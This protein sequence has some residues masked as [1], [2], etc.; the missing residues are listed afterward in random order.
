MPSLEQSHDISG[1]NSKHGLREHFCS[2]ISKPLTPPGLSLHGDCR[3]VPPLPRAGLGASQGWCPRGSLFPRQVGTGAASPAPLS[4]LGLTIPSAIWEPP[5]HERG[6]NTGLTIAPGTPAAPASP[7]KINMLQA[8]VMMPVN[9]KS[10]WRIMHSN[11]GV[12]EGDNMIH[13]PDSSF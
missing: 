10:A 4:H 13:L 9:I 3:R 12:R 7:A 6:T 5:W 1:V 2:A 11:A 8:K